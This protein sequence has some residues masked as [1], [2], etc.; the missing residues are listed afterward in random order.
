MHVCIYMNIYACTCVC[1][2][3]TLYMYVRVHVRECA[4][5]CMC[6]LIHVCTVHVCVYSQ[7]SIPTLL[8]AEETA[9]P[10]GDTG[11][12]SIVGRP[13]ANNM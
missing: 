7:A 10:D 9:F 13:S 8:V 11:C 4:S 1:D 5:M 3:V 2:C 6:M 12:L